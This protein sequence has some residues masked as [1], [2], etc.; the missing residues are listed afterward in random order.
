MDRRHPDIP[1]A[2]QEAANGGDVIGAIKILREATGLGLKEAKD[3]IDA[4]ALG[5]RVPNRAEGSPIPLNA[6][7]SL[8]Q[9]QFVEAIKHTREATGLGL[10]EAKEAVEGYLA[11]HPGIEEQFRVAGGR[12]ASHM[13]RRMAVVAVV[14]AAVVGLLW[15]LAAR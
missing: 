8:H 6:L 7:A 10:K 14:V 2:A 5:G 3:A 12:T 13:E 15:F 1:R 4:Y 11:N 9:G